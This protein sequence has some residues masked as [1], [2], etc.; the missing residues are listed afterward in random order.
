[1]KD[2][3]GYIGFALM[4]VIIFHGCDQKTLGKPAIGHDGWIVST[5]REKP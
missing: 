1:M 3:L 4:C 2:F 5:E